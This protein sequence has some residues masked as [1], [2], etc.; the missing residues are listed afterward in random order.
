MPGGAEIAAGFC[1]GW[2]EALVGYPFWTCKTLLQNNQ[3]LRGTTL[4]R[5]YRGVQFPLVSSVAFNTVV[6]PLKDYLHDTHDVPYA[7]CGAVAGV[8]V[9]PQT[10]FFDTFTIR[11][12]TNQTLHRHMFRGARGL[13]MTALRES[14]ALSAYFSTYHAMRDDYS[15]FLS[16][17]AAGVV[18]WSLT[19]PVDTVRTRQIAQ[20]C[21]VPTALRQGKLWRGLRFALARAAVVNAVSFSVYELVL[22]GL[23]SAPSTASIPA[24]SR[25][26]PSLSE[27]VH[28]G[29]ATISSVSRSR[30]N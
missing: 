26:A 21:D 3:S 9:A 29:A 30:A 27:T 23:Q 17:A 20:K 19:F 13:G 6:F 25:A 16:G 4:R 12:Q 15:A 2:S 18:N 11:R 24:A 5:L 1:V 10:C 7:L 8:V 14:T 28:E 22:R